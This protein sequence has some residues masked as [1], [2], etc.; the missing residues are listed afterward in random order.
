MLNKNTI[1]TPET[2]SFKEL[3]PEQFHTKLYSQRMNSTL[4]DIRSNED[5][6]NIHI[7]AVEGRIDFFSEENFMNEIKLLDKNGNY[8]LYCNSGKVSPVMAKIMQKEGFKNINILIGGIKA[9]HAKGKTCTGLDHEEFNRRQ[10][11]QEMLTEYH[12]QRRSSDVLEDTEIK[13]LSPIGFY[14]KLYNNRVHYVLID[15][16]SEQEYREEHIPAVEG[17]INHFSE[18]TIAKDINK[19][20]K[21][22]TYLMYCQDGVESLRVAKQMKENG[23]YISILQG[24]I[25]AWIKAHLGCTGS[26]HR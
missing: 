6:R 13:S 17:R 5:Y 10:Q 23:F 1:K 9:W 15:I 16:R 2:A 22:N 7:P 21:Q 3:T 25:N 11:T 18:D 14:N 4:I 19:L 26:K 20:D 8:L 12:Q 24:G